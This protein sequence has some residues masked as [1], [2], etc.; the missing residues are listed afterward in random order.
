MGD[1]LLFLFCIFF[2]KIRLCKFLTFKSLQFHV[3][4]RKNPMSQSGEKVFT[5]WHTDIG[6]FIGSLL[7]KCRVPKINNS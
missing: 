5:Y 2:Q 6:D 7:P 3:E 4:F 1:F